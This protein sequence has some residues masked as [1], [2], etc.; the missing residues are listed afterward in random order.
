ML[1]FLGGDL[2]IIKTSKEMKNRFNP[3]DYLQFQTLRERGI[4][5]DCSKWIL[6]FLKINITQMRILSY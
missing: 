6:K 5:K 2:R 1:S 3:F 4:L